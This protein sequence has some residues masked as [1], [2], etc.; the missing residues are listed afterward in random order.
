MINQIRVKNFKCFPSLQMELSDLTIL[1][2]ANAAGKSTIIQALLLAYQ[3]FLEKG[4]VVDVSKAMGITIGSPKAL[5]SDR[6][7]VV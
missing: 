5:I 2:G 4:T 6:K 1:S 7:S 3:T